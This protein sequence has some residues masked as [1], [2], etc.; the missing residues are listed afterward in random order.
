M[1]NT[2]QQ[3]QGN[4]FATCL[5]IT[6]QRETELCDIIG[7]A[8]DQTDSYPAAM[9]LIQ[10]QV[11]DSNEQSYCIFQLGAYA[12]FERVKKEIPYIKEVNDKLKE[13]QKLFEGK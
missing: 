9:A 1:N 2:I 12:G 10:Q 3:P 8:Y 11:T 5:N 13:L 7:S 4:N 6:P